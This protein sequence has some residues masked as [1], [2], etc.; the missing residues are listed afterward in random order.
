MSKS[1]PIPVTGQVLEWCREAD[2]YTIEE[3]VDK[4]KKKTVRADTIKAWENGTAQPSYKDCEKLA[5]LYQRPLLLFFALEPP[6]QNFFKAS[7]RKIPQN[8]KDSVPPHI[9]HLIRKASARQMDIK[10][11]LDKKQET[12]FLQLRRKP[13]EA[14]YELAMRARQE[15]GI[16]F[17]QPQ[18]WEKDDVFEE[19]R[20]IVEQ[21]GVWVFKDSFSKGREKYNDYS[22]F[23][24][25]DPEVPVIYVNNN[26]K[27]LTRQVFTLF[28]ELGHLLQAEESIAFRETLDYEISSPDTTYKK[29]EQECNEFAGAF[30]LPQSIT[31]K[32]PSYPGDEVIANIA[33][34]YKVSFDVVLRRFLD[35]SIISRSQYNQVIQER[36]TK[37]AKSAKEEN[38]GGGWWQ[39]LP[40]S[41][42]LFRK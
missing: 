39:L 14:P 30:L 11:L 10:E 23:S 22:G 9:R 6:K 32:Y 12:R 25:Y 5:K 31:V 13:N 42:S 27:P 34:T 8:V 35:N 2:G 16:S 36:R 40:Y 4:I 1:V 33:N 38:Q 41:A 19:W 18:E 26:D 20:N 15:L 3:V 24:I 7:Y 21:L 17:E 28:H 29:K 37:W